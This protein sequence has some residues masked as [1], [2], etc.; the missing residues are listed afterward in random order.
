[1]SSAVAWSGESSRTGAATTE[2]LSECVVRIDSM[3]SSSMTPLK[4]TRSLIV[5]CGR[6]LQHDRD[7][8]AV[9]V[10]VDQAHAVT[11][12]REARRPMLVATRLLPT[13]PLVEKTVRTLPCGRLGLGLRARRRLGGLAAALARRSAAAWASPM[14]GLADGVGDAAGPL[15]GGGDAGQVACAA[16]TS[17]MPLRSASE[18]A[19]AV[20]VVAE[21]DHAEVGAVDPRPLGELGGRL[22]RRRTG[23]SRRRTRAGRAWMC[24]SRPSRSPKAAEP[25][26]IAWRI[27]ALG[28]VGLE[29]RRSRL[30]ASE[31]LGQDVAE[32]RRPARRATLD[33]SVS[34]AKLSSAVRSAWISFSA[35]SW[36]DARA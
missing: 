27:A 26:S 31:E 30:H 9:D 7:V 20:D 24:S 8:A 17:R 22:A 1:M 10:E 21:Q 32:R 2:R 12:V 11:A 15:D 36:V 4:P 6:E 13:P 3:P 25:C 18:S 28:G 35:S 29:D 23:R 14:Q 5:R 16:T 19:V 33:S 34:S